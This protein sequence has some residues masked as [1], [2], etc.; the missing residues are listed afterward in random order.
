MLGSLKTSPPPGWFVF[1]SH[2]DADTE[3]DFYGE[4]FTEDGLPLWERPKSDNKIEY[5]AKPYGDFGP[6]YLT[7]DPNY[8]AGKG[9]PLFTRWAASS[10]RPIQFI[11]DEEETGLDS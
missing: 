8:T 10:W 1:G 2:V 4:E 3:L 5:G 6:I 7:E 11:N 9:I